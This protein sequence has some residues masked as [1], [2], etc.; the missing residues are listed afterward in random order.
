VRWEPLADLHQDHLAI[1]SPPLH[2]L[3]SDLAASLVGSGGQALEPL[4]ISHQAR[5]FPIGNAGPVEFWDM[6]PTNGQPGRMARWPLEPL[7][8]SLNQGL[9]YWVEPTAEPSMP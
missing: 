7:V 1:L 5:G 6:L 3:R 2:H 9:A 8:R 4:A